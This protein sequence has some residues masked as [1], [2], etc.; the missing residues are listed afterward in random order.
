ML[1][2]AKRQCGNP[3]SQPP[4][5]PD[6][7]WP[8][9][10]LEKCL[11][12]LS[13]VL[14]LVK[15]GTVPVSNMLCGASSLWM[16]AFAAQVREHVKNKQYLSPNEAGLRQRTGLCPALLNP[17]AVLRLQGCELVASAPWWVATQ[18][19]PPQVP[20]GFSN[21]QPALLC[22]TKRWTLPRSARGGRTSE[23]FARP[24]GGHLT[25]CQEKAASYSSDEFC[26]L[27]KRNY[28]E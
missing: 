2:L 15:V 20:A 3:R 21:P 12:L 27:G 11:P 10:D 1:Q 18:V 7:T 22:G 6:P 4:T 9:V 26:V 25:M 19:R 28:L 17:L 16:T 14:L 24:D 8:P 13:L 5:L 23:L